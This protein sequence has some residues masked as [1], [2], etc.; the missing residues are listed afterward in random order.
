MA[1]F[2][3]APNR[4]RPPASNSAATSE[5]LLDEALRL[6]VRRKERLNLMAERSII[7]ARPGEEGGALSG[8][9]LKGR[10]KQLFDLSPAFGRHKKCDE[11]FQNL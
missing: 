9:M 10:M 8:F 5:A 11:C 3:S 1:D 2:L 6:L 4:V 7:S